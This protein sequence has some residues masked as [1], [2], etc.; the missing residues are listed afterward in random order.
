MPLPAHRRLRSSPGT[1]I[2]CSPSPS[3][4]AAAA[5]RISRSAATATSTRAGSA[6]TTTRSTPT[7]ARRPARTRAAATAPSRP[8]WRRATAET[9]A[10]RPAR[11]GVRRAEISRAAC[12]LVRV[13]TYLRAGAKNTPTPVVPTELTPPDKTPTATPT[14]RGGQCGD[15]LLQQGETCDRVRPTASRPPAHRMARGVMF[16]LALSSCAYAER[17]GSP[18]RVPQ[19]SDQHSR[20]RR[21]CQRPSTRSAPP[22]PIPTTTFMGQRPRLRR[23]YPERPLPRDF[24]PLRV[25]SPP[26]AST[27]C[28]GAAHAPT[29]DDLSCIIV[30]CADT[31][32]AIPG[33]TCVVTAQP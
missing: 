29:V 9:P 15:G 25:R 10:S 18:A 20:Q 14:P 30:R 13:M 4:R 1:D 26:R 28:G 24:R 7:P 6:T 16:A 11:A 12:P 27:S 17:R 23:R 19:R 32:G 22:P 3:P 2:S 33:C 31:T 8:G 5:R 21:R